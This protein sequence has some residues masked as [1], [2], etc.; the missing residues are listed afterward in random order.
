MKTQIIQLESHDDVDS[1]KDKMNWSQTPRILLVW[2]DHGNVLTS[3]LDLLFLLRYAEKL[4]GQLAVVSH[5]PIIKSNAKDLG[6]P[7]FNNTKS[8]QIASWRKPKSLLT[9]F[10]FISKVLRLK[11]KNRTEQIDGLSKYVHKPS[12]KLLKHWAI[13]LS[14]F[15]LGVLSVIAIVAFLMPKAEIQITPNTVEQEI[16]LDITADTNIK[17]PN[18][19]GIVPASWYPITVEGRYQ[20]PTTGTTKIPSEYSRGMVTFTNLTENTIFIPKGTIVTTL[21]ESVIRFE[22]SEDASVTK[23]NPKVKV[24][25]KAIRPGIEGN[26]DKET[27]NAIEGSLGLNLVVNNLQPTDQGAFEIFSSPTAADRAKLYQELSATM[28]ETAKKEISTNLNDGDI[29]LTPYPIL[30][31]DIQVIYSPA[32]E[33]PSEYL[34]LKLRQEYKALIAD[35]H[36]IRALATM[37]LNSNIPENHTA[38]TGTLTIEDLTTP[39]LYDHEIA[40]WQ[41]RVSRKLEK[42]IDTTQ[43]TKICLGLPI[44][45]AIDK[46]NDNFSLKGTPIIRMSPSWWPRMP[47][48]PF[49]ITFSKKEL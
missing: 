23:E 42:P 11:Q 10:V 12:Q 47:F 7:L 20:I 41:I 37:T 19:N 16:I 5:N 14:I 40:K 44:D 35:Y 39:V 15:T 34:E 38:I 29:L 49:R 36:N 21:G 45:Q 28:Q 26:V 30:E 46:L 31:K 32:S 27:I 18:I 25:I 6:I 48:V 43:A 4:G 33:S 9:K 8:A 3:K 13:R 24:P 2:L 17:E 1:V 22:T